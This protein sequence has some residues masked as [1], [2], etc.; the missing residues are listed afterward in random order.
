MNCVSCLNGGMAKDVFCKLLIFLK[1]S[2]LQSQYLEKEWWW[3]C[4]SICSEQ[5]LPGVTFSFPPHMKLNTLSLQ[6]DF[7]QHLKPRI[8]HPNVSR[9]HSGMFSEWRTDQAECLHVKLTEMSFTYQKTCCLSLLLL[10]MQSPHLYFIT[11]FDR[12]IDSEKC[13]STPRKVSARVLMMN[14]TWHG[15]S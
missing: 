11:I 1:L 2:H 6:R 7:Y 13:F 14:D 10:T 9:L 8:A 12:N 3:R 15:G 5:L 4:I